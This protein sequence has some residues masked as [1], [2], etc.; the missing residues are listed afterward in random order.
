[1]ALPTVTE[2][3]MQALRDDVSH[4][5]RTMKEMIAEAEKRN[6]TFTT[7]ENEKFM[8]IKAE[9]ENANTEIASLKD[10]EEKRL[11]VAAQEAEADAA[12]RKTAPAQI[13]TTDEHRPKIE[14]VRYG[15]MKAFKNEE[16][17]YRAG[18]WLRA[19][20][21]G[22]HGANA[23]CRNNG[24]ET[25]SLNEA[26]NPA[27]GFL[28]PDEFA[29]T[30]IDLREQYGVFRRET[31]VVPMGSD[32]Y[33]EPVAKT[34]LTA[35]WTAE[36]VAG[37]ESNQTFDLVGMVA[38][39]MSCLTYMSTEVAE[40]AVID[41]ADRTFMDIG[42]AFSEK[43]DAA[44]FVGTGAA[45]YSGILGVCTALENQS[46]YKGYVD[47]TS[48]TDTFVE[49]DAEDIAAL[50]AALP[51]RFRAGAKFY[52]T[53][54]CFSSV[55]ERLLANA[56][57]NTYRDVN[58]VMTPSYLG[59]PIVETE[60]MAT[61]SLNDKAMIL[62]GRLDLASMLGDRRRM[63]LNT[64]EHVRFAE[65]MVG[66]KGTQRIDINVHSI[67]DAT[68]AGPIVALIGKTS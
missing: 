43:E 55:F 16:R 9:L 53:G 47:A 21:L 5:T 51:S 65:D 17:A 27:G 61:S 33:S 57:G 26:Y 41:L 48:G 3:R 8:A 50:R 46:S 6:A 56:G 63:T 40:D 49:I 66:I 44:G 37:T 59:S 4:Y 18:K 11:Y 34:G 62:Y 14:F 67:G 1:M 7:E 42:I 39:K 58:G 68:N 36:G 15:P 10:Q 35:Y 25:R 13:E 45:T 30:I 28:V 38:K 24:I 19:M 64:S 29:S 54:E 32:T 22:D 60:S 31:R 12:R 2:E 52:C 20:F 23:W